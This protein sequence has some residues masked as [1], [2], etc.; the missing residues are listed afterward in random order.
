MRG[1]KMSTNIIIIVEDDRT[2]VD[3]LRYNLVKEGYNVLIAGDG[4]GALKLTRTEEPDLVLFT[5]T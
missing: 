3:V 2:L 4:E 1:Q 5:I